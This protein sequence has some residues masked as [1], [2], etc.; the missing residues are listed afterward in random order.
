MTPSSQQRL[1]NWYDEHKRDLPWRQTK[2]PY[3]IWISETMLQQTTSRAVIPYYERFLKRFPTVQSLAKA[4]IEDVLEM[5][6]GLGYYSR[7][8]NLHKAAKLLAKNFPNTHEELLAFPGFGPYTARSVA[9]LAFGESVG[10]LDGNV[11]R[12]LSRLHNLAI[13]W[14]K[15]RE[16]Q[17]LQALA[18]SCVRDVDSSQMNQALMELGA[19]IC[20]PQNPTCLMCPVRDACEA[21]KQDTMTKLPLKKPKRNKEIWVWQ[22]AV[23]EKN[24]RILLCKSKATPFFKDQWLLPGEA[25][26]VKT[27][28]KNFH[29]RHS[30]THHDIFVTLI[31]PSSSILDSVEKKW[32]K[33]SELRRHVPASLVEKALSARESQFDCL[34]LDAG[35]NGRRANAHQSRRSSTHLRR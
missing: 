4:K 2:D 31:E 15:P 22:T 34:P 1:L 26:Q 9:S 5:W 3:K 28:P 7:A 30:I 35:K 19:T 24:G 13:E 16:R 25:K 21:R 33:A 32:V 14:W 10:V 8:R 23:V 6:A 12:V 18:D 17:A 29:F 27:A 20:M 11:I